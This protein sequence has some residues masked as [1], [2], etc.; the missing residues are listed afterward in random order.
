MAPADVAFHGDSTSTTRP[1]SSPSLSSLGGYGGLLSPPAAISPDPAFIAASAASQIVTSDEYDSHAD[2]W[3]NQHA[4]EPYGETALVAPPALA[5]VNKFLDQLLFNFLSVSKS[6]SLSSLRPAVAEVLR[7]KLSKD[8]IAGADQELLEYLGGGEEEEEEELVA[9]N[10]LEPSS[11]WDLE[12]VWKRTRLRCMVYSSLGDLEEEDEEREQLDGPPGFSNRLSNNPGVV[13]PAAAI[14]LTSILEYMGEQVLVV[15]GQAA[16][17]RLRTKTEKEEKDASQTLADIV[18]RVVVEENDMERVALDRTLG[19]LW[20]GW[21]KRIRSPT[22]SVSHSRSFSRES[23]HSL[24][25]TNEFANGGLARDAIKVDGRRPSLAAVLAEIEYAALVPLPMS[26]DDVREIEIPGLAHYTHEEKTLSGE[27]E[28]IRLPSRPKSLVNFTHREQEP[29]ETSTR[30]LRKRSSSLPLAPPLFFAK[31][32]KPSVDAAEQDNKSATVKPEH[33]EAE[34]AKDLTAT[35]LD[36]SYPAAEDQK[37]VDAGVPT[38][39]VATSAANGEVPQTFFFDTKE[40]ELEEV[41]V[42]EPRIVT[43]SRVSFSGRAS[44]ED[45]KVTSSR[46]STHSLRLID[47]QSRKNSVGSRHSSVDPINDLG[48]PR[49]VI[50]TRSSSAYS[51]AVSDEQTP[52][53][54]SPVLGGLTTS[55]IDHS[56]SSLSQ[57]RAR[58]SAGHSI[59]EA[60]EDLSPALPTPRASQSVDLDDTPTSRTFTSTYDRPQPAAF[61]L[62]PAPMTKHALDVAG[63]PAPKFRSNLT[64]GSSTPGVEN[65]VPPLTPL[66]EMMEIARDTS[67]EYSSVAPS[68]DAQSIKDNVMHEHVRTP[69]TSTVP[70]YQPAPPPAVEEETSS[71]GPANYQP[72]PPSSVDQHTPNQVQPV[73]G[74]SSPPRSVAPEIPTRGARSLHTSRSSSSSGS[75]RMKA[76]RTSED[77]GP[78]AVES[79]GQSFEQLIR[80]DQT[81]Q[82]TLTPH[83]MREIEVCTAITA[84]LT[85]EC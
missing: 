84:M 42:E 50:I 59:S 68:T 12:H 1:K 64:V 43:S 77:S 20:R 18:D 16:Y 67:D 62:A 5:L 60:E 65:G 21:K 44:P 25:E 23:L 74:R 83:N 81:I 78:K 14:F 69:S 33:D 26:D 61:V 30:A 58:S 34:T 2:A 19:R 32:Q 24:L 9:H 8:A 28:G 75:H 47:V 66:R 40:P 51:P 80:S 79:K 6:T 49:S 39:A 45:G 22:P 52:R 35:Q 41:S 3:P 85:T 63:A 4:I 15:A 38:G 31:R 46:H 82:Y 73:T 55:P 10:G 54:G 70:Y 56:G 13:S 7:P 71:R 76:V 27:E 57:R 17:S 48:S 11:E 29:L 36:N 72:A 37:G 53:V